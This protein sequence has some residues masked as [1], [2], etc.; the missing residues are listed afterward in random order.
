MVRKRSARERRK[1]RGRKPIRR[2]L[3][4]GGWT[5]AELARLAEISPR[6]ITEYLA[7]GLLTPPEFRGPATRYRR[8]HLLRLMAIREAKIDGHK[9]LKAVKL[10]LEGMGNREVESWLA[11]RRIPEPARAA[12]GF[13]GSAPPDA[14][15]AETPSTPPMQH[16]KTL[17]LMPGLELSL[18]TDSGPVV[19]KVANYL[20]HHVAALIESAMADRP[21]GAK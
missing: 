1:D 3:P 17:E 12:L 10:K 8:E 4:N 6:T 2:P 21:A 14:P 9:R 7:A 18:R 15:G 11:A 5:L 16:W 19:M 13:S 20:Y